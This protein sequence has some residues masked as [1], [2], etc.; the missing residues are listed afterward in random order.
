MVN[1]IAR[2]T[3]RNA[4]VSGAARRGTSLIDGRAFRYVADVGVAREFN[5][6]DF[7]RIPANYP[8]NPIG[9]ARKW[10]GRFAVLRVVTRDPT[11]G[12]NSRGYLAYVGTDTALWQRALIARQRRY[13]AH[14]T[15]P[16]LKILDGPSNQVASDSR[17]T[18]FVLAVFPR[19]RRIFIRRADQ[20]TIC[21]HCVAQRN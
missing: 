16:D 7:D 19:A 13:F 9:P 1:I 8:R 14:F 5:A 2:A 18:V 4:C 15:F 11:T 3:R 21:A 6:L 20:S 10:P 17:R 12:A